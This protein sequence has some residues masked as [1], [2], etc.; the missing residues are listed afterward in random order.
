MEYLAPGPSER[1]FSNPY[2]T[3]KQKERT[4]KI[5]HYACACACVSVRACERRE[6]CQKI[7]WKTDLWHCCHFVSSMETKYR[8]ILRQRKCLGASRKPLKAECCACS[9]CRSCFGHKSCTKHS[10]QQLA[11]PDEFPR[12]REG[13]KRWGGD[14]K[15]KS[16]YDFVFR[17]HFMREERVISIF[18]LKQKQ[19]YDRQRD[20]KSYHSLL[21]SF[22]SE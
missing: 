1:N 17:L 22:F 13:I 8:S 4:P 6:R 3:Q 14:R 19:T 16:D 20:I 7:T 21:F 10:D 12:E 2:K 18:S 11:N 5:K 9:I 15:K